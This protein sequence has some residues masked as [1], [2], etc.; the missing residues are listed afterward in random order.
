[1]MTGPLLCLREMKI[2]KYSAAPRGF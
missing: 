2:K 1:M